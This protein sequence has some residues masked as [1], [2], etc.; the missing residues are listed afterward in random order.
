[1][2]KINVTRDLVKR[3][4]KPSFMIFLDFDG[5]THPC[6]DWTPTRIEDIRSG[7][8]VATI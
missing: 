4:D 7:F 6:W 8:F 2:A 3:F 5:V 1:V